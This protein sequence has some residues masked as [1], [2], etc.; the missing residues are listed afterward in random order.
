MEFCEDDCK[1][2]KNLESLITRP[3]CT[4]DRRTIVCLSDPGSR[5]KSLSMVKFCQTIN[6]NER[7]KEEQ[8]ARACCGIRSQFTNYTVCP[9]NA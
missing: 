8:R 5:D 7:T 9:P 4:L 3:S 1:S 2:C 6:D